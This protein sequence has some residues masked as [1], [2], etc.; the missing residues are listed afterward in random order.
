MGKT[1]VSAYTERFQELNL[2]MYQVVANET[3]R[4]TSTSVDCLKKIYRERHK[5][6]RPKNMD[7]TIELANALVGP[8]T[9]HLRGKSQSY[10]MD[11]K[12]G[13][14]IHTETTMVSNNIPFKRQE[15]RQSLQL[16]GQAKGILMGDPCQSATCAHLPPTMAV[17]PEDTSEDCPKLRIKMEEI[18]NTQGWVYAVGMQGK[19]G[20]APG[21]P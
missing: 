4:L 2:D 1:D 20:N 17:H 15:C 8:E 14:M 16:R 19:R 6:A 9:P 7:E 3:R 18:G 11:N 13:L 5:S 12:R 10:F 21:K